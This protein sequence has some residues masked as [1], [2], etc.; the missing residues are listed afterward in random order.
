MKILDLSEHHVQSKWTSFWQIFRQ[1]WRQINFLIRIFVKFGPRDEFLDTFWLMNRGS[2]SSLFAFAFTEAFCECCEHHISECS[3][4]F[5]DDDKRNSFKSQKHWFDCQLWVLWIQFTA[6]K[7][8]NSMECEYYL[9][10]SKYLPKVTD[11]YP[12]P[13]CSGIWKWTNTF[14]LCFSCLQ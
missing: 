10:V 7:V 2:S 5:F 12:I 3:R 4:I 1:N 14:S 6:H 13:G 9:K 8:S 11:E